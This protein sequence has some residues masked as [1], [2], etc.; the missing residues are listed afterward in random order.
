MTGAVGAG[1]GWRGRGHGAEPEEAVAPRAHAG[2][3]RQLRVRREP[4]VAFH[5]VFGQSDLFNFHCILVSCCD[6][7]GQEDVAQSGS[8]RSTSTASESHPGRRKGKKLM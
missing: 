3:A 1:G 2:G 7:C 5:L 6:A 4:A 8:S